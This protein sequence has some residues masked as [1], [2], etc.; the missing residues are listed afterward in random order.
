MASKKAEPIRIL[1][2]GPSQGKGPKPSWVLYQHIIEAVARPG[3]TVELN[4]LKERL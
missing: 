2:S 1:Y 3:T 4:F